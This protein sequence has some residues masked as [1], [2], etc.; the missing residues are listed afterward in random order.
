MG[1]L[2]YRTMTE[3]EEILKVTRLTRRAKLDK[4]CV[5]IFRMPDN[6]EIARCKHPFRN[7]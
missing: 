7:G 5:F 2:P 1:C 3:A 4:D 6:K